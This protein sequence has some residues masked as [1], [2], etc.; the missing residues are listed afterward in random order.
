MGSS[1]LYYKERKSIVYFFTTLYVRNFMMFHYSVTLEHRVSFIF[2]EYII[3][4]NI[5]KGK[6]KFKS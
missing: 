1:S 6:T 3:F 5:L 2:S 4:D